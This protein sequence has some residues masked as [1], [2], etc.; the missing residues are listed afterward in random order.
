[1]IR[2]ISVIAL[3]LATFAAGPAAASAATLA[4]VGAPTPVSAYGGVVAWSARDA[5]TGR[6]ALM[7]EVDGVVARVPVRTRGVPF[8][9][10]LGPAAGGGVVAAYSRCRVE[11]GRQAFGNALV[12]H[13]GWSTGRGCRLRR[14]DFARARETAIRGGADGASAYLPSIWKDRVAFASVRPGRHPRLRLRTLGRRTRDRALVPGA[15]STS[16]LIEPG[17][18]ALDLR[19]SRLAVTWDAGADDPTSA[20]YLET[21]GRHSVQRRRLQAVA[22]GALQG[23]ELV[24]PALEPGGVLWA[25][26]AFGEVTA[27]TLLRKPLPSGATRLA[28]FPPPSAQEAYQRPVLAFAADGDRVTY[29]VS[30]VPV[31]P[32]PTCTPETPCLTG[33]GCTAER[34]CSL[35]VVHGLVPRRRRF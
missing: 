12:Q 17:P 34:P 29:L 2:L 3:A 4:T 16:G 23:Q 35:E 31:T 6:Y 28:A 9:L 18:T 19:G 14:Y 32:D 21:I 13:P 24:S 27:S 7:A 20:L 15:R 5:A 10:D 8:D 33:P 22:S 11:P 26:L 30:G 25:R 1:M